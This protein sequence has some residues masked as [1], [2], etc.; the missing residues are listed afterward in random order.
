MTEIER[1]AQDLADARD[2][3]AL[4]DPDTEPTLYALREA[5]ALELEEAHF[6]AEMA[7]LLS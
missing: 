7:A 5:K 6:Q 1:L 3:L 2:A 4:V